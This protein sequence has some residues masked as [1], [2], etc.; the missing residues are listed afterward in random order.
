MTMGNNSM[1]VVVLI[2]I[3]YRPTQQ[4]GK[5]AL[6]CPGLG[7]AAYGSS[8]SRSRKKQREKDN[9]LQEVP[10]CIRSPLSNFGS[11]VIS[12]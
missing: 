4:R 11:L 10:S 12:S 3:F 1:K 2:H 5:E 6:G 8:N 9:K 7:E